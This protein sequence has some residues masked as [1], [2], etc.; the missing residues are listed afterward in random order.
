MIPA[1]SSDAA[2]A[3]LVGRDA[4]LAVLR[5]A[6]NDTRRGQTACVFVHGPSGLGKSTLVDTFTTAVTAHDDVLVLA[7]RCYEQESV[8]YKALDSLID[9]LSRH[10]AQL[11]SAE[12]ARV[13]PPEARLLARMFPV[14][15]RLQPIAEA[16]REPAVAVSNKQ[17]V[18]DRAADALRRLLTTLAETRPVVLSVDDL[19]WGD[20]DSAAIIVGLLSQ[21]S[22]PPVLFVGTYRS[23]YAHE[24]GCLRALL[25][26]SEA[27]QRREV[28]VDALS[29]D[30]AT[31]LATR[32]LGGDALLG[33][34]M[35]T[36]IA[37]E[38]R[39][40]PFFVQ[41]LVSHVQTEVAVRFGRAPGGR[42]HPRRSA[43]AAR[44]PPATGRAAPA[45]SGRA[46]RPAVERGRRVYRRRACRH[47]IRLC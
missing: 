5:D 35:A 21:P 28:V 10:L 7:G 1:I 41:A 22:P 45:R 39:G 6:Y 2:S 25:E 36:R 30:D 20:V 17:E 19:Q 47:A 15:Q 9:A 43:A 23:E 40:S 18:R 37:E 42:H 16:A 24:S 32:L 13:L 12:L 14:L 38:S 34:P 11:S 27:F 29:A 33:A 4:H 46:R 31:G 8:R 26:P 44:Q 3:A